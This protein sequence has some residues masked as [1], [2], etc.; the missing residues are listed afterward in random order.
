MPWRRSLTMATD[1][2]PIALRGISHLVASIRIRATVAP[3]DCGTMMICYLW[4]P[5]AGPDRAATSFRRISMSEAPMMNT[6]TQP[7]R[8]FVLPVL[9]AV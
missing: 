7:G 6:E 4:Q 5:N 2:D 1:S 8:R 9:S 3:S